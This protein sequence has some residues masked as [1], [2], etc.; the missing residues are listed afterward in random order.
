MENMLLTH[1]TDRRN[2][3]TIRQE[4]VLRC[5]LALMNKREKM[6]YAG[7][8]RPESMPV[9]CGAVLR[10]QEPLNRKRLAFCDGASFAEFVRYLN[11][12]V[13]FWA[14]NYASEQS[15]KRFRNKYS[16]PGH[17]GIRCQLADLHAANSK[18]DILYSPYNSGSTPRI[19]KEHPRHLKLFQLLNKRGN[20]RF[21]EVVVR[22]K[23]YLPQKTEVE[24]ESGKWHPFFR[25]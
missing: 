7:E 8:R 20:R 9:S 3:E 24:Y 1:Y 18:A 22:G 10:D 11:G 15:R 14:D 5:A 2:V 17:I 21:V 19:P 23:V 12:H 6:R 25:P 16:H 13:F 4:G